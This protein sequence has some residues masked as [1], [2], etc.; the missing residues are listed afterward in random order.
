MNII[1]KIPL[2]LMGVLAA[3]LR[4]VYG[5]AHHICKVTFKYGSEKDVIC[6]SM[7][8]VS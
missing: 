2:A 1:H 7:I 3:H 8:Y 6:R 5:S 4:T